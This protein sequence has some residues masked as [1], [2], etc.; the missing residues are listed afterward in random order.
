MQKKKVAVFFGGKSFEHDISILTGIEACKAVDSTKYEAFPIYVDLSGEWWTGEKLLDRRFYPLNNSNRFLVKR[1]HLIIGKGNF[2]S[3][4]YYLET[5]KSSLFDSKKRIDF[6]IALLAFHGN[7]GEVGHFQGLC[8]IAGIPYTGCDVKASAVFMDKS[9]TKKIAK[10]LN[11]PVLEEKILKKPA[12]QNFFD[13]KVLTK[14]I[15]IPFPVIVKPNSLGSSIGV[16]KAEN[17]EELEA[18]VL[19]IF[20]LGDDA[21]IEPFVENLEEYNISVSKAF[22]G[23]IRTSIIERPLKKNS[24]FLGFKDKYMSNGTK[25]G[26]KGGKLGGAK[27][28]GTKFDN[29]SGSMVS[30]SRV[31]R[32]EELT[33][34]EQTNIENW[35]KAIFESV[36]GNGDPR[37]DFM[38]NSKTR[39]I[40]LNEINPIPGSFAYYLWENSEYSITQTELFTALIEEAEK[41]ALKSAGDI[42]LTESKVFK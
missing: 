25:G 27:F 17:E 40:Y 42:I 37:I 36:E 35:A 22:D 34:E 26:T 4:N 10:S 18:G 41:K 32:P 29:K 13:I 11:I 12:D 33:H 2:G 28:G 3:K 31:Y 6:D 30:L 38:C 20:A 14:D 24:A 21:L 15:N 16:H 7:Y 19:Q 9:L 8:E 23:T 5:Q 1:V 39:Q